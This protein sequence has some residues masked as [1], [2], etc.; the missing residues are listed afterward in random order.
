MTCHRHSVRCN[1][2]PMLNSSSH[3]VVRYSTMH[4]AVQDSVLHVAE[5]E[6]SSSV[7]ERIDCADPVQPR[8][9]RVE[10]ALRMLG[11]IPRS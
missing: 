9:R 5:R 4:E 6:G 1:T 2:R 8:F 7:H 10:H 11:S 3:R